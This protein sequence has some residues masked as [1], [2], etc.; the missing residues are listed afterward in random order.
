MAPLIEDVPSGREHCAISRVENGHRPD[1]DI[2][3]DRGG[4]FCDVIAKVHGRNDIIFKL[5]SEDPHNYEDAPSEAIRQVLEIVEERPIPRGTRLD[6]SR[7]ASCRIGTTI[8]TNALLENKGEK[9]ALLTTKGF[10]DVCVIGDQ[11]RPKIFALKV[12][13]AK[14]LHH[15][16]VEVDERIT[17][18]DYDLNPFPMNKKAETIT[19]DPDLVR[20]QSGEIIRVLQRIDENKVRSQLQALRSQGYT[21]IAVS[22]L[23][24]YLYPDHENLV[25]SMA[26]ELGFDYVTTSSATSPSIKYLRRSASACSEAY[27]YPVVRKYI[28]K[29]E[30]GFDV[31]PR[32]FE[33]MCSD[34]GLKQAQKFGGNEALLSG[35]AGGVVGVAKSCYDARE[36]TALIGFDMGG[37][38]TDVSR[39]DG[40]YDYVTETRLSNY[41]ITVP[42]LNIQTVAAGGGSI[43]FARNGL[44]VVG[45]ES[46]GAY[47]GPAS[48]RNGG[49]LTVTDANLFLGRLDM[50]SFPAIFG[51]DSNQPL[52]YE[53]VARKFEDITKDFN[54]QTSKNLTPEEVALGFLDVANET[55]SRP[56]RNATEARGYAPENHNLV[57]FGGAGGQHAC[58]IADKLGIRRILIHKWSSLLSAYGISQAQLQADRSDPY[59]GDFTLEEL[60]EIRRRLEKLRQTVQEELVA[61]GAQKDSLQFDE[62]LSLRYFG[63]DTNLSISRPDD[64]DYGKAF[65]AEHLREFSFVLSGRRIV[66][67][68]IQVRGTGSAGA[69]T[70]GKTIPPTE[71][72]DR[73][74]EHPKQATTKE[75]RKI[76][77]NG[78]WTEAS[79]FRLSNV[80]KG[81]V[82]HGPALILDETQTIFV[83]PQFSSYFLSNHVVIERVDEAEAAIPQ[84]KMSSGGGVDEDEYSP[85]QLS[86]FAHRFMS[87]AEQM[88][89]TLQRTAI[90][91]SIRERLDFSCAIFS[92]DGQL[93]ANAPHIPIH[94]GSMQ[95]AIQS[96]H[97][98][99][100]GKLQPGDVLLTNHPEWGGTH[101]PDITVVTPVFV[102]GEIAFY[103]A[104]RGHHTDIGGKGIT[105]M[106]PDSKELWEEGLNVK[107]MKIVSGGRFLEDEVRE[108]FALAGSFPGCSPT[109]RIAD[110]ISDLKAQTSANQRGI[111]LLLK[112]CEEFTLP[113]VHRYMRGIQKNAEY[114]VRDFFRNLAKKHPEGLSATDCYDNGT[115]LKLHITVDPATGSAVYDFAGSGP[116]CWANINCPISI[117][118]SAVIYTI[119]CLI[120]V[121]MPLN[122]GCLTPIEIRLP[123]GSIL[124]PNPSV[125]ICGSTI[126][127]QRVIDVI[128][129]AYR[130][131]AAFQG[132]ASSF[133]WGMGGRNP[134]TGKIEPGWNYGEA[135]GGGTGAGPGWHGEHA[136]QAHS[137]NTKITDAE[138]IE[139][140]TPVI[141]RRYEI[142]RGTGGRG[143][144]NGGDGITREI[145][146]RLPLK[147]SILSERRVFPPYGMDGG[148][149]GSIGKNYVFRWNDEGTMDKI[150]LGGQAIVHLKPGERMQINTPGGGGWGTPSDS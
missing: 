39:F 33:F 3:I 1:I 31:L 75:R 112:L 126:A 99:W 53:I 50:S 70:V 120:D 129:R 28:E 150:N 65:A 34:G 36:G 48:Y 140:R 4:T 56:I 108:A 97:R 5:L 88:G 37:T 21:S 135:I 95:M 123:K 137:T 23:H 72:L 17:I 138:V 133:G 59:A 114:A 7:I 146:A 127:S 86:V 139:K 131:V 111:N 119:R 101:L 20:T 124:N 40:T 89:N 76:Y 102:D 82:V 148:E 69:D 107:S 6:G 46:A 26:K 85:I 83:E 61:Q 116:Q 77:V 149:P 54:A 19:T 49:P 78:H 145:E 94:L 115:E 128:L 109:R 141:V 30:A 52:D 13:K 71:E 122:Q 118:Y 24:S 106:M 79:I 27:L 18:E 147:F 67:D 8:A 47:P 22:F 105:S 104:S 113:V 81:S 117:T 45:P 32:R 64:E 73:I 87:I 55:M 92:A 63:T 84:K 144:W 44:L 9:F 57:S 134:E 142:N 110:N 2:A 68:A 90:S 60:P 43:L 121:D 14:A 11:T 143:K 132:C 74:K 130:C 10:K 98:L 42:M 41:I 29:V 38:S 96:Q 15:T 62:R 51:P 16:V 100:L 91:T 80:A 93:V 25:A 66:I 58:A 125:A 35:P 103:T 136:T 12:E